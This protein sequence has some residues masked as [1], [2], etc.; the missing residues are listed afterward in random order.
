MP[1]VIGSKDYLDRQAN[2]A[3]YLQSIAETLEAGQASLMAQVEEL[4]FEYPGDGKVIPVPFTDPLSSMNEWPNDGT[5]D[6]VMSGAKMRSTEVRVKNWSHGIEVPLD[7]LTNDKAGYLRGRVNSQAAVVPR[8]YSEIVSQALLDAYTVNGFD[9][10]PPI[11]NS[12]PIDGTATVNDNLSALN[13]DAT[14]LNTALQMF[15]AMRCPAGP[16]GLGGTLLPMGSKPTHLIC[17]EYNRSA[18]MSVL[19]AAFGASGASN[20]YMGRLKIIVIDA[21]S[22]AFEKYWMLAD[23]SSLSGKPIVRV[24]NQGP[25]LQQEEPFMRKV[26][27]AGIDTV[28]GAAVTHYGLLWGSTGT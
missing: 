13:L 20:I 7:D 2:W 27:R 23:L 15:A 5:V 14:N 18:A 6:R 24:I 17:G 12:H 19:E 16:I 3:G 26:M 22:G 4:S 8:H 25:R 9:G 28:D 1:S 21:F 11:D 10:V